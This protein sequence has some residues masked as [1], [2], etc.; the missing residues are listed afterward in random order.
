MQ[1]K[2]AVLYE[3]GK[4][5]VIEDVEVL[6]RGPH[7]VLVRFVANGR[8]GQ[9]RPRGAGR[10]ARGRPRARADGGRGAARPGREPW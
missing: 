7:E 2:A 6:E 10:A 3:V 9:A 5:L 4:S 8:P 1:A